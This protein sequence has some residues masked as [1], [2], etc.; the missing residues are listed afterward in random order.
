MAKR[1]SKTTTSLAFPAIHKPERAEI[2]TICILLAAMIL[3]A[4][5]LNSLLSSPSFHSKTIQILDDQKM[6]ALTLSVAVTAASTALSVLPDDTASPIAEELADLSLPLFLI[7]AIIYLE[8]FLLTTF[9]WISSVL[10]I[11]AACLLAI[12]FILFKKELF[13]IW[14]KKILIL[15]LALILLIPL[16]RMAWGMRPR[17]GKTIL[18]M[19]E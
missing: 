4:T 1:K 3:S 7:V 15:T 16:C 11:P 18:M 5:M 8:I 10:L 13:L 12:G 2:I 14:I 17:R 19:M 9:G 6:E